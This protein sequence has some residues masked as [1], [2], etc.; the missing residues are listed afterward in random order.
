MAMTTDRMREQSLGI[1][2]PEALNPS[3]W[4]AAA[5]LVSELFMGLSGSNARE[6]RGLLS[7]AHFRTSARA[8]L[9]RERSCAILEG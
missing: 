6:R 5:A 4:T 2:W 7:A 9:T 1:Q 8:G 3:R